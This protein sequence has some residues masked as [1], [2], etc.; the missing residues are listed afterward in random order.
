MEKIVIG[1]NLPKNMMDI[2]N[3]VEKNLKL[4]ADAKKKRLSDLNACV[5]KRPRHNRMVPLLRHPLKILET[6]PPDRLLT[7]EAQTEHPEGD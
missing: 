3:G 7:C 2:D 1:S 5:L 4:L 6:E